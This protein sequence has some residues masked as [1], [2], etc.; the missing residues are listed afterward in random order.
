MIDLRYHVYSLAA[1][2]FALA[3]GI[4]VGSS[5]VGNPGDKAQLLRVSDRYERDLTALRTELAKQQG[6]LRSTRAD[7]GRSERMCAALVPVAFKYKLAGRN[8]AIIQTGD[9]D[10]LAA[11]LR[12]IIESVGAKVTS[13]TKIEGAFDFASPDAV[14]KAISVANITPEY[15]ESGKSAIVNAI[16]D[17]VTGGWNNDMMRALQDAGVVSVSGDYTRRNRII[18]LTGG[19]AVDGAG[20][21]EIIDLPMIEHLVGTGVAVVGCEPVGAQVSYISKWKQSDI[22]T[23]DNADT[24]CGQ[25]ALICALAGEKAHFGQ[26]RTAKRLIPQMLGSDK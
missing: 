19:G 16:A 20:R 15:D 5:F 7:F 23:V 22:A 21:A 1:V 8:V 17:A 4:V 2:F 18:V 13:V 24:A 25:V 9:Y 26:K 14:S 6:S 3:I 12:G 10:E 11:D